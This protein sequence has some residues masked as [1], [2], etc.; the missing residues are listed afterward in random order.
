MPLGLQ[1]YPG[2]QYHHCCWLETCSWGLSI[3][4]SL[5]WWHTFPWLNECFCWLKYILSIVDHPIW[6]AN[7]HF[8]DAK[9]TSFLLKST[10]VLCSEPQLPLGTPV[11]RLPVA[12]TRSG[13]SPATELIATDS[14]LVQFSP[15]LCYVWLCTF[16]ATN[17]YNTYTYTYSNRHAYNMFIYI[18]I[19]RD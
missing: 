19:Y 3:K 6:S 1:D 9:I 5:E 2:E 8:T 4:R 14:Q 7:H 17:G 10:T 11:A 12:W 13:S 18:Y 15:Q 16:T